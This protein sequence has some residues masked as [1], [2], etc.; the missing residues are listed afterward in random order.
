M[1][2]MGK[3][4]KPWSLYTYCIACFQEK[5]L[6][7]PCYI[8]DY[9][10]IIFVLFGIPGSVHSFFQQRISLIKKQSS[11]PCIF[12]FHWNWTIFLALYLFLPYLHNWNFSAVFF[13]Q[14]ESE[15]LSVLAKLTYFMLVFMLF[16]SFWSEIAITSWWK[17]SIGFVCTLLVFISE[18]GVCGLNI[19][20]TRFIIIIYGTALLTVYMH[21]HINTRV[22]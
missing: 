14:R 22:I 6:H 18:F 19:I 3:I 13:L 21:M 11:Y 4:L 17:S 5:K 20:F 12:L 8:R 10:W 1:T 16:F 15:R 7:F 2:A 9:I